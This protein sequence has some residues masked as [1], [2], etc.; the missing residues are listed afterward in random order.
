MRASTVFAL[1]LSLLVGLAA[2]AAAKYAGLF[3]RTPPSAAA[4]VA[5]PPPHYILVPV[6]PLYA[7]VAVTSNQVGVRMLRPE[8]QDDLSRRFGPTWKDKLLPGIPTA[9]HQRIPRQDLLVDQ[10]L[11]KEHFHETGLPDNLSLRL[12]TNTRAVNVSVPRERAAGGVLQLG[13]YVDVWLTTRVSD[14]ERE[15]VGSACI[16][17]A[18]KIIMKRNNLW[19]IQ[20]VDPDGPLPFTLQANLY[21][22]AL[23]EY[24][25][26][27]GTLSL[28]P[29]PAPPKFNGTWSDP[30]SREYATEDR[31][32]E[33]IQRGERTISDTD[34]ARIFNVTPAPAKPAPLPPKTTEHLLGVSPSGVSVFPSKPVQGPPSGVVPA[35]GMQPAG[36]GGTSGSSGASGGSGGSGVSAVGDTTGGGSVRFGL[37]NATGGDPAGGCPHCGTGPKAA[38]DPYRTIKP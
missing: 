29:V 25:Q 1:A 21:R 36:N 37:P 17:R 10:I 16:A 23:I 18:C 9:A 13:E 6:L 24:A 33:E 7:D 19:R 31:R 14:G 3:N 8:E 2:A 32:I 35:G 27:V 34:L 20:G 11:F 26:S 38:P 30:T 22:A 15:K 28:Q 5:P 4:A 12:E